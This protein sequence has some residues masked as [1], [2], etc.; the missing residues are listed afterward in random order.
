MLIET[1]VNAICLY[2]DKAVIALNYKD[3]TETINFS[4]VERA[5]TQRASACGSDLEILSPPR[6]KKP[7]PFRFPGLHKSRE[8]SISAVS[9]F[10]TKPEASRGG[11]RFGITERHL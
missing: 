4:E 9:F 6:Q 7:A 2:D 10:L 3:G 5:L 11:L 8:S 1:F